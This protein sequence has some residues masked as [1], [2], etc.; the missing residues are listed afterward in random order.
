[1]STQ[2]NWAWCSKCQSLF[3]QP[4]QSTSVC[5]AGAQHNGASSFD[6]DL[7][8]SGN[9]SGGPAN[10]FLCGSGTN[11]GATT[12]TSSIT[13][14]S[15]TGNGIL[16]I[17]N[18][19]VGSDTLTVA[20]TKSNTYVVANS[21]TA[22][23]S[24]FSK[25]MWLAASPTPLTTSDTVTVTG[26]SANME[27]AVIA[28]PD[29]ASSTPVDQAVNNASTSNGTAVSVTSGTLAQATELAIAMTGSGGGGGALTWGSGWTQFFASLQA[30]GN[31]YMNV[32]Y[33][34]TSSTSAVTASGTLAAASNWGALLTTFE[35]V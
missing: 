17:A 19:N 26:G 1:M 28:I 6:Y 24:G 3:Y 33:Q 16:V 7:T 32:A 29:L 15:G 35:L 27:I 20:D 12:V 11:G 23:S 8:W 10:P 13:T 21:E 22:V 31:G 4:H 5:P 34:I 18:A 30:P 25:Y 9:I 14:A 2:T